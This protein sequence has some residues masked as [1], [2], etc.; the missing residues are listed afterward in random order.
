MVGRHEGFA[1][2]VDQSGALA[3]QGFGGQGRWIAAYVDG[4]WVKLDKLRIA[5]LGSRQGRQG[6]AVALQFRRGCGDAIEPANAA[7]RQNDSLTGDF[8]QAA[9]HLDDNACNGAGILLQ[10]PCAGQRRSGL[11]HGRR[12]GRILTTAFMMPRPA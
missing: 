5:D 8:D 6:Q 12:R 3:A 7:G 11:Q 1:G 9:I 2:A 10:K 4:C